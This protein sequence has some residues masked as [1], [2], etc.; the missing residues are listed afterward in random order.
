MATTKFY[1]D[2]RSVRADGTSPLK[3]AISSKSRT[4]YYP[5]D[6]YLLPAQWD[7]RGG[8]IVNHPKKQFLNSFINRRRVE[9]EEFLLK[10]RDNPSVR[11]LSATEIKDRFTASLAPGYTG[12]GKLSFEGRFLAFAEQKQGRTKELYEFTLSKLRAFCPDL[13]AVAWD[14]ITPDW[15]ARFDAYL[16][17]TA[18]KKN[19]RNIH[20]RNIRAVFNSALDAEDTA[21][22]PF[23][24][25]K[26]RSEETCK[27]SLT[28]DAL[29][30]LFDYPVEAY[31]EIYRDMFK[32]IFMLI[33]INIV[34]LHTLQSIT[35]DGRIE[36]RRSK[37]H[38]L[39]SI[40]LEPEALAL[41]DKYRGERG[42]LCIADRW[43]SHRTFCHQMNKALQRIGCTRSGLG[44]RK[45]DT[46]AFPGLTSYWARH[47]WATIAA[48][49]DIPDATISLA[50][51]HAGENRTTDIYI[52]R[53]QR[54]V[55]EANRRVLDWVL[56]GKK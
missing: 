8:K 32:L 1:L 5:L 2:R 14:E 21:C 29:R 24:R 11:G 30:E 38:R 35:P 48:D 40:K 47:T 45:S 3:L 37:T 36:F 50:L 6:I 12:E 49:L 9:C 13:S 15:L 46:G 39:F 55:D 42:L 10:L 28:L 27:R 18:H 4:A 22:Y 17:R 43:E 25:F 19:G 23:R 53:N 44:G 7:P 51:G 52:R 34:D 16:A 41:I 31:A 33:G 20:L 26:I 56:Y 54:K